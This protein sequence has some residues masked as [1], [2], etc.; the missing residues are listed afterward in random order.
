MMKEN[1]V[2]SLKTTPFERRTLKELRSLDLINQTSQLKWREVFSRTWD[3]K[4]V[5]VAVE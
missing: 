5:Y 3:E 1:S 4:K 2:K